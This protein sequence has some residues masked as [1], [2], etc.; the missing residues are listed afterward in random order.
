MKNIVIIGAGGLAREVQH[1]IE[2]INHKKNQWNLIGFIDENLDNKGNLL[3]GD[4]IIGNF[5]DLAQNIINQELYY[6]CAIG[7]TKIKKRLVKQAK[8]NNL[9]P[10]TLVDPD[11]FISKSVAINEGSVIYGNTN[12]TTNID[13]GK[14]VII[15]PGCTIGHDVVVEDYAIVLPGA[16]VSGNVTIGECS[17]IGASSTV[18]QN[19]IVGK[20]SFVGAGA[21]VTKNIDESVTVVG[22]PA[23]PIGFNKQM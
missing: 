23:R 2:K 5:D 16:R 7:N 11:I 13:I 14:H 19:L 12:L 3:N 6:V 21:V 10:A 22:C 8:E 15:N 9:K 4:K 18:I 17:T 20:N 1:V